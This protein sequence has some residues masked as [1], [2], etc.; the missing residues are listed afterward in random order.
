[1]LKRDCI[2]SGITLL[3]LVF[4]F[5]SV[6]AQKNGDEIFKERIR[7]D[8]LLV[9]D[10]DE[11]NVVPVQLKKEKGW[12]K[13]V[14]PNM[15]FEYGTYKF[16]IRSTKNTLLYEFGFSPIFQEYQTTA[17]AKYRKR[18]FYNVAVFPNFEQDLIIEFFDRNQQNEWV[19]IYLDSINYDGFNVINE[20]ND[21]FKIDTIL[22]SGT[23]DS[24]IDLVFLAEGYQAN[25]M[26]KF[27][28][29][30]KRM[31]TALFDAKPYKNYEN[32][33]NILAVEVPS[34]ETG[35]DQP[36]IGDFKNTAFNSSF[37]TFNSAR[38]LTTFDLE[39]VYDALAGIAFDHF[40]VLVNS[41][42]YGGG[43][44]YNYLNLTTVDNYQSEFVFIHEFGHGFAG[45]GDEYYTSSTGYDDQFYFEGVEPWEPNI[46]TMADF[47]KKWSQMI[48]D[49]IPVPTPRDSIYANVVGAFE[50]GGYLAKG[51]FS[52]MEDCW[53]NS[54][55]AGAFCPVCQKA[56]ENIILHNSKE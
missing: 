55:K 4:I 32:R 13:I 54:R 25:Q 29:D 34:V 3:F 28:A 52:P 35:M 33:F 21:Q 31:A 23:S 27:I 39:A 16:Q 20:T 53:M 11:V 43:G 42:R 48:N 1:M 2:K 14:E 38:Y 10:N 46:T 9:G 6:L 26:E 8:Y 18:S 30:S 50:G 37:N 7:Y 5:S 49:T 15:Q 12:G 56:I 19:S 41:E 45:L 51:V 22:W 17:E 40:F 47:E 44:F 36:R 24:K